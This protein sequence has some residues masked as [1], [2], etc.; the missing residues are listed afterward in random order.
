MDRVRGTAQGSLSFDSVSVVGFECISDLSRRG[1]RWSGEASNV[2]CK[3]EQLGSYLRNREEDFRSENQTS[4]VDGPTDFIA[5]LPVAVVMRVQWLPFK[6]SSRSF[7]VRLVSTNLSP[8]K[9][10]KCGKVRHQAGVWTEEAPVQMWRAGILETVKICCVD[11]DVDV[12]TMPP[13][14]ACWLI[15]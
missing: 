15:A 7:F 13:F 6:N 14:S 4:S 11:I 3:V 8:T 12:P 1:G 5:N 9:Q 2:S 10:D